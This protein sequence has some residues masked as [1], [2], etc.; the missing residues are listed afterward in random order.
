MDTPDKYDPE[1]LLKEID[2]SNAVIEILGKALLEIK[3]AQPSHFRGDFGAQATWM[4]IIAEEALS[5]TDTQPPKDKPVG[6]EDCTECEGVGERFNRYSDGEPCPSCQKPDK[7]ECGAE[8][9]GE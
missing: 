4:R 9:D 6:D 5:K 1:K 8:K 2:Q 3:N 7:P